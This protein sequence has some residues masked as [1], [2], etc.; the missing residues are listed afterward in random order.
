MLEHVFS[1]FAGAQPPVGFVGIAVSGSAESVYRSGIGGGDG[2]A[3]RFAGYFSSAQYMAQQAAGGNVGVGSSGAQQLPNGQ[4]AHYLTRQ[5]THSNRSTTSGLSSASNATLP[6]PAQPPG[7]PLKRLTFGST[8]YDHCFTT[9]IQGEA[10][11]VAAWFVRLGWIGIVSESGGKM[12]GREGSIFRL[13]GDDG[14]DSVRRLLFVLP[15]SFCSSA[16]DVVG[17]F[18]IRPSSRHPR[19]PSTESCL[20]VP[21]S[22]GSSRPFSHPQTRP[23]P[24]RLPPP[25]LPPPSPPTHETLSTAPPSTPSSPICPTF[26]PARAN[27]PLPT[28]FPDTSTLAHPSQRPLRVP[29]GS[30]ALRRRRRCRRGSRR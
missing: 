26:P 8:I 4:M 5:T 18:F 20:P 22:P 29:S 11:M 13:E 21:I 17:S 2:G 16:D 6:L 25:L 7:V 14:V 28:A 27:P 9:A 3:R 23:T 1:R 12:M 24:P 30:V 15:F 10:G 19:R